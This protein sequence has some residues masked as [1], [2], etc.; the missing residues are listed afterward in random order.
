MSTESSSQDSVE[1]PQQ[2]TDEE[3]KYGKIP[4]EG[5]FVVHG[6]VRPSQ[7]Y[8]IL[9]WNHDIEPLTGILQARVRRSARRSI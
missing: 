5:D 3:Q 6:T 1:V 7:A 9:S 2:P 8:S 4:D